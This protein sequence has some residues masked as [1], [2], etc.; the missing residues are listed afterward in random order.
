MNRAAVFIDAGYLRSVL[1]KYYAEPKVDFLKLSSKLVGSDERFRTYYYD[2]M[3]YRGAAPTPE[4]QK[5]YS[6]TQR[7]V[8]A[9]R[10]IPRFEVK[11]GRL[12]KVSL[13]NGQEEFKQK[14]VDVML[15]VDLVRLAATNQIQKAILIAGDSDYVPAIKVAKETINVALYFR[16]G[17]VHNELLQTCDDRF[18]MDDHFFDDV[19]L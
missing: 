16:E 8:D 10:Y 12:Q 11:L 1:R 14:G 9:L 6:D 7:F 5:R 13:P 4:E 2:C 3:P 19:K 18:P 15:S 17:T